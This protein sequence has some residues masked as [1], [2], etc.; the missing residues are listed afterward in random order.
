[1][2]VVVVEISAIVTIIYKTFVVIEQRISMETFIGFQV[3]YVCF[4][5]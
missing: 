2:G 4:R 3:K 1:M 5:W